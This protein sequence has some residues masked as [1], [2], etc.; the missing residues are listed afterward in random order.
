MG[1]FQQTRRQLGWAVALYAAGVASMALVSYGL[2][3]LF[4]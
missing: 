1:T 3:L 2:E 4:R